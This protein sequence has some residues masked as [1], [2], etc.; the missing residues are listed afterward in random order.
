MFSAED[1]ALMLGLVTRYHRLWIKHQ[2]D[3]KLRDELNAAIEAR[4]PEFKKLHTAFSIF[5]FD[6]VTNGFSLMR[7]AIGEAKYK[8]A[9]LRGEAPP[10]ENLIEP[11]QL[12]YAPKDGAG[13]L[14]SAVTD[15]AP[16][17][18][19]G[20]SVREIALNS[21]IEAGA[22]GTKAAD[23]RA[24]IERLRGST[25]HEKTVGMTL[26][27]LSV[28]GLARRK[29][30]TWFYVPPEQRTENPG[31]DTPGQINPFD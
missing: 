16:K 17:D 8:A 14:W 22:G 30:H 11:L 26:Y 29:G 15:T 4:L 20:Q 23:I 2:A 27:R 13:S 31:G 9:L 12:E 25:L 21:L 3:K 1:E 7:D 5:G 28:D 10:E 6:T 19:A 18:E 24:H